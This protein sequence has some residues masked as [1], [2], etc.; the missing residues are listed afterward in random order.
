MGTQKQWYSRESLSGTETL[1]DPRG[2][3][4]HGNQQAAVGEGYPPSNQCASRALDSRFGTAEPA[5]EGANAVTSGIKRSVISIPP[6]QLIHDSVNGQD[7][8][9]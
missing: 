6:P 8:H 4:G 1:A 7:L 9:P 5:G 2:D 3:L